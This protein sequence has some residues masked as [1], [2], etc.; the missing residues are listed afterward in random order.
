VDLQ[1]QSETNAVINHS[2]RFIGR[3]GYVEATAVQSEQ[4]G[5]EV[6][7]LAEL[8]KGFSF[9]KGE[10]Y[11]DYRSG[12]KLAKVALEQF[13]IGD[14][15]KGPTSPLVTAGLWTGAVL[16]VG[17]LLTLVFLMIR[18]SLR[19][20]QKSRAY[21]GYEDHGNAV[22]DLLYGKNGNG[23]SHPGKGRRREFNYQKYY[24][25]MMQEISGGSFL[26]AAVPVNGKSAK[27]SANGT[28][29][30][31]ENSGHAEPASQAIVRANAE[32]IAS[33]TH[34][35]EEQKRLLQEQTRLIEE[36]NRLIQERNEFFAKQAELIERDL[37]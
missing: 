22:T 2:I 15:V 28:L 34:L 10:R 13:I 5:G 30:P 4:I 14:E 25:D 16:L 29:V 27:R 31:A 19:R 32:L 17:G 7:P 3:R 35:I 18:R 20:E 21:P 26:G 33:Q 23:S 11:A 9:N 6:I 8:V 24:A 37:I 12:D 1:A 36:K